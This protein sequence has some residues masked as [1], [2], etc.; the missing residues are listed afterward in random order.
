MI[1]PEQ[2]YGLFRTF[3]WSFQKL[4]VPLESSSLKDEGFGPKSE[5]QPKWNFSKILSKS[6]TRAYADSYL[7]SVRA[8]MAYATLSP[9]FFFSLNST[10]FANHESERWVMD[11]YIKE[12]SLYT[13]RMQEEQYKSSSVLWLSNYDVL[14]LH[15]P[16]YHSKLSSAIC[17][18]TFDL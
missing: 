2:T 18:P 7:H 9:I 1:F 13:L 10:I 15:S 5:F 11:S 14:D 4:S 8:P 3:I 16:K 6:L 17:T 12:K